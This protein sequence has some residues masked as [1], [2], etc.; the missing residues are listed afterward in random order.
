MLCKMKVRLERLNAKD[1]TFN[2][3]VSLIRLNCNSDRKSMLRLLFDP[4]TL[5]YFFI[6]PE[7]LT[8]TD[9]ATIKFVLLRLLLRS[10]ILS[11]LFNQRPSTLHNMLAVGV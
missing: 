6:V 2:L 11:L 1:A 10:K 5:H 3:N 8:A 9:A 7:N 4:L